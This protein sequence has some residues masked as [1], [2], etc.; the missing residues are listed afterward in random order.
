[1]KITSRQLS[2]FLLLLLLTLGLAAGAT[3]SSSGRSPGLTGNYLAGSQALFDLRT[4]EAAR[5]MR[6]ALI[7]GWDNPFVVE[8]GFIAYAANGDIEDAAATGRRLLELD[9]NNDL[10]RLVIATEAVKRRSYDTAIRELEQV[11]T[12]NF[13]G[14][15]GG[16]L[17]A[18]AFTGNDQVDEATAEL[19]RIG[20]NGLDDFLVFHRALMADVSGRDNEAI[21]FA[22]KSYEVEPFVA[23]IVEAYARMLGN[24]GRF[25]EAEEV[26]ERYAAEGLV[27]PLVT[28]VADAVDKRRRPGLFAP[29]VQAG[30]A[31]MFHG[32]GVALARDGSSDLALVFL[33]LGLY[34]NPEADV[35]ALV[36]GQIL[37]G[38]GEHQAANAVYDRVAPDSPLKPTATVRVAENLEAMGK[39]DE[40]LRRLANIVQANPE[41]LDALS[42]LG[43]LQR[44]AERYADAAATYTRALELAPGDSPSDWRFYYVRGIAYERNK[45]WPKAEADFKRALQ[46]RPDQPQVLNYLGYSWVDKGMNL[47]EALEMIEAA[48]AAAPND[49]YIVDSL[50]WAFYKLGRFEE[51]VETLERAVQLR[52]DD[53][54]INDHLG[55]AYWRAGRRLEARFQWKVA[56]DVDKEGNVAERVQPKLANGLDPL[57]E[58]AKPDPVVG[59]APAAVH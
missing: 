43:D 42:V 56:A 40:A 4:E 35:I 11:G 23:R 19:D 5:F 55:D 2:R 1:V 21:E 13:A 17:R 3:A 24:A 36:L 26:L 58:V 37:D 31:E 33:R 57:P 18:W 41:D 9:P 8:R 38:A 22:R 32:I 53:P 50:G 49:G 16:I 10:A 7:E 25:D 27:H 54:E 30:A 46:L 29:S 44:T 12:D 20:R 28:I 59:S 14:I 45:E 47:E 52:S 34:L 6:Q 39:R 15:T 48:V 51:A